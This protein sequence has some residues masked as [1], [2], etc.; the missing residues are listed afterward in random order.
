MIVINKLKL[1]NNI[2]SQIFKIKT[3]KNKVFIFNIVNARKNTNT[4]SL[5]SYPTPHP[6]NHRRGYLLIGHV[7]LSF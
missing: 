6:Q 7:I 3:N 4:S 5:G 1:N 2:I